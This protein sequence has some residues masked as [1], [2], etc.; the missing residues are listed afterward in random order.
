MD[1]SKPEIFLNIHIP[2]RRRGKVPRDIFAGWNSKEIFWRNCRHN[3]WMNP[4]RKFMEKNLKKPLLEF[5]KKKNMEYLITNFILEDFFLI[6]GAYLYKTRWKFLR[7]NEGISEETN[8]RFS[9]AIHGKFSVGSSREIS[10]ANSREISED[11]R[12]FERNP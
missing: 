2:P 4:L 7:I 3:F 8:E 9:R 6:F 1:D 12:N 11:W 10:E 5:Q